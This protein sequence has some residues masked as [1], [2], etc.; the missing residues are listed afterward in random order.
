MKALRQFGRD[1]ARPSRTGFDR[2]GPR[3]V[4]AAVLIAALSA[5]AQSVP[6]D[7][8]EWPK[9]TPA[10]VPD[11]ESRS[12]AIPAPART[13]DVAV[14]SCVRTVDG[15]PRFFVNGEELTLYWGRVNPSARK[16]KT[17]HPAA[18]PFNVC[19]ASAHLRELFS[20]K[21]E[22][23][24][25]YLLK[26]GE[27]FATNWPNAWFVWDIYVNPPQS[28]AEEHP[29]E[30]CRDDAGEQTSDDRVVNWSGGS[31]SAMEVILGRVGRV[32]D[33]VE[34][35]PFANRVIAYRINSGHTTEWL[36][37]QA[38]VGR[39]IDFSPAALRSFRAYAAKRYGAALA[40]AEIPT[41]AARRTPDGRLLWNPRDHLAVTAFNE[42]C[43]DRM[44]DNLIA[45]CAEA[46][47][48]LGGRKAVGTYYG[49]TMTLFSMGNAQTRAHFALK[50]VLESGAVDFLCSP[51]D[52][53]MRPLGE[54][55]PDM[56]PFATMA[57]HGVLP[58]VEDDTRT[59]HG[60]SLGVFPKGQ[61]QTF[62]AAQSAAILRRNLSEYLCRNQPLYQYDLNLGT[63][64][65]FPEWQRDAAALRE[66]QLVCARA[67]AGRHAEIAVVAG[68]TTP[69]VLP[70]LT[71]LMHFALPSYG[72]DGSPRMDTQRERALMAGELST[73]DLARL[74]RIGAPVDYLLAEDLC[75]HPGDY[76][77]YVFLGCFR[78]DARFL[79]AVRRL[80]ERDCTLLWTYAPGYVKGIDA[81]TDNMRELTG[82]SFRE[83]EGE[84]EPLAAFADGSGTMGT[85]GAKA[86]PLFAVGDADRT[87]ATYAGGGEPAVA[88]KRTGK[89]LSVYSGV[90]LYDVAFLR[91]LAARSGVHSYVAT[92]DPVEANDRLFTL[93]ARRAGT[94]TVKLPRKT[95]VYD[96][97]NRRLVA[98][99]VD[100]FSF[101][102]PIHSTWLFY[103]ADDAAAAFERR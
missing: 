42:W 52:Y 99:Q 1:G 61:N 87:L 34:R 24:N 32:V 39:C 30:I 28:W 66:A 67:H 76:R 40:A 53:A 36:G 77:M 89:A 81:S 71:R 78:S 96:V 3:S 86:A 20:R 82:F 91:A 103:C 44:A 51:Q 79:E 94:K 64:L 100:A 74:S 95:D 50:K 2:G 68:E 33:A 16:D 25:D 18:L 46:K 49:Y 69:A 98:R 92:D 101:E 75:D 15:F 23:R 63:G 45:A 88:E 59:H 54:S 38:K 73:L 57:A 85:P 19:T 47:R 55:V 72:E 62:T 14:T 11:A 26:R 21:G 13:F 22:F 9:V 43:S 65:D 90:W 4:A 31:Q 70:N 102:A 6:Y 93:H 12:A 58:V 10:F 97:F 83:L 56:K 29:D 84:R 7:G 5:S 41:L 8:P 60:R 35:S 48:R 37:W 80:R 27:L 17:P